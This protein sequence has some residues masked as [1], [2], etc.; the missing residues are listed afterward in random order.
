MRSGLFTKSSFLTGEPSS[1]FRFGRTYPNNIRASSRFK[2]ID[3]VSKVTDCCAS[4]W[5]RSLAWLDQECQ[6]AE[7]YYV[8]H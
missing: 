1:K 8:L 2:I 4:E 3:S 6:M 7:P 5:A